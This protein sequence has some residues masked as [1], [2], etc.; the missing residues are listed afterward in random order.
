M[1]KMTLLA[2][3]LLGKVNLIILRIQDGMVTAHPENSNSE[4]VEV[5]RRQNME[6]IISGKSN[7][8]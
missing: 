3:L 6:V 1:Y 8:N 5:S 4:V 7:A 2:E